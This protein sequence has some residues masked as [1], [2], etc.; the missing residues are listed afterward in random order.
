MTEHTDTRLESRKSRAGLTTA[1][2]GA[3]LGFRRYSE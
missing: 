1:S 3:R 2:G